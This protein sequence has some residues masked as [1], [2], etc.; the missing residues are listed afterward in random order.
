MPTRI[1]VDFTWGWGLRRIFAD[2]RRIRDGD[3]RKFTMDSRKFT[4]VRASSRKLAQV[5]DAFADSRR[6]RGF[7][8]HFEQ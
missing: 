3:S 5:R 1:R 8:Q 7:A 2:S 4:Q 6:I